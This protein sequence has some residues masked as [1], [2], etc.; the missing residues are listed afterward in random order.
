MNCFAFNSVQRVGLGASDEVV[1]GRLS[2]SSVKVLFFQSKQSLMVP[3][4]PRIL[5]K[6]PSS[7]FQMGVIMLQ[8]YTR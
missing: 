8:L 5:T 7:F 3:V 2:L 6:L 1:S 4:A